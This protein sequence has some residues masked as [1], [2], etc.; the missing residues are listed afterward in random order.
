MWISGTTTSITIIALIIDSY[1]FT[2][3]VDSPVHISLNAAFSNMVEVGHSRVENVRGSV[4][5]V[6]V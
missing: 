3:C 6:T 1:S 4:E 5:K 2:L